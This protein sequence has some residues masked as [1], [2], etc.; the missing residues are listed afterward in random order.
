MIGTSVFNTV[1]SVIASA[2]TTWVI[3]HWRLRLCHLCLK[4]CMKIITYKS[5]SKDNHSILIALSQM[6]FAVFAELYP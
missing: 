2:A 5:F 6:R 4:F 1:R 3:Q